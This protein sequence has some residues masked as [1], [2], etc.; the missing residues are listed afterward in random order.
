MWAD[1][2]GDPPLIEEFFLTAGYAYQGVVGRVV[3]FAPRIGLGVRVMRFSGRLDTN[4]A[5]FTEVQPL[6]AVEF[7]LTTRLMVAKH[8]GF[9]LDFA[10]VAGPQWIISPPS[11]PWISLLGQPEGRFSGGLSFRF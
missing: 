10:L 5:S 6:F 11:F 1:S 3:E 9:H 8:F 2:L 7:G 4:V